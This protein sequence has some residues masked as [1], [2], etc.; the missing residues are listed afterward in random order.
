MAPGGSPGD[1]ANDAGRLAYLP[2]PP[3]LPN[4]IGSMGAAPKALG[5][6]KG[7]DP[8]TLGPGPGDGSRSCRVEVTAVPA[9]RGGARLGWARTSN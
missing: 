3:G 6:P 4:P 9:T 8:E 7:A 5:I 2:G 1:P